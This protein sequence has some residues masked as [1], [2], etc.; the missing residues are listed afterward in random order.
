LLADANVPLANQ[1]ACVVHGLREAELEHQGLQT[2]L[3]ERVRVQRE[4]VIELVLVLI[5][6]RK[7]WGVMMVRSDSTQRVFRSESARWTLGM[8]DANAG[9][10]CP[11]ACATFRDARIHGV[12]YL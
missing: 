3:Q 10:V 8:P 1:N 4:H 11:C 9:D 12:Y 2:A 5:L 7:G 6:W